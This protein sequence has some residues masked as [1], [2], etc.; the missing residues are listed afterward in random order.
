MNEEDRDSALSDIQVNT[1]VTR[2]KVENM[3]QSLKSVEETLE[4]HERR[5]STVESKTARNSYILTGVA[6]TVGAAV[7][8]IAAK[9]GNIV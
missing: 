6:S 5:L 7:A 9:I 3:D 4:N 8:S 1:A 2:E